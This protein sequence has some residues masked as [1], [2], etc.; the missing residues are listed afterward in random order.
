M[1][2]LV[3]WLANAHTC[4]VMQQFILN[5]GTIR[6]ISLFRFVLLNYSQSSIMLSGCSKLTSRIALAPTKSFNEVVGFTEMRTSGDFRISRNLNGSMSFLFFFFFKY[7]W[8]T[9]V[10][11]LRLLLFTSLT[12]LVVFLAQRSCSEP[13]QEPCGSSLYHW[14][15]WKYPLKLTLALSIC[16]RDVW[17][18]LRIFPGKL[19]SFTLIPV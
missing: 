8:M 9:N 5:V 17:K 13:V 10:K 2:S 18:M 11:K 19:K 16:L 4:R 14:G 3:R 15:G 7:V 6:V 1:K 12:K